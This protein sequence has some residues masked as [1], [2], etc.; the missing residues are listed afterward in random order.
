MPGGGYVENRVGHCFDR[1]LR[2]LPAWGEVE[3]ALVLNKDERD[4]E[5][6][7]LIRRIAAIGEDL[8][9][10]EA[11]VKKAVKLLR[12][13]ETSDRISDTDRPG[14]IDIVKDNI[15]EKVEVVENLNA[16]RK[17]YEDSLETLR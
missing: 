13:V 3:G 1:E 6:D 7:G 11:A 15:A 5:V 8:V 2:H 14:I 10:A 4:S 9:E 16:D 12:E 17:K